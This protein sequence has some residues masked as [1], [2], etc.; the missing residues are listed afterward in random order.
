MPS[1]ITS[2]PACGSALRIASEVSPSG[3]PAVT[4]VTSAARPSCLSAAK[5]WS[6]RVVMRGGAEWG[7]W[8]AG[9]GVVATTR[10]HRSHADV[11]GADHEDHDQGDELNPFLLLQDGTGREQPGLQEVR[12][13]GQRHDHEDPTDEPLPVDHSLLPR[14][15]ATDARSLS[16]RPE[17]FTTI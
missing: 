8:S 16:P 15:S 5:R 1:S 17:R 13:I 3:S 7:R 4:N 10:P 6:M 11:G 9:G 14:C 2:A 12:D